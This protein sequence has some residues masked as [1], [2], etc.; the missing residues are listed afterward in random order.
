MLTPKHITTMK[1]SIKTLLFLVLVS[2]LACQKE[3]SVTP[4]PTPTPTPTKPD[5]TDQTQATNQSAVMASA[6]YD[7]VVT[8]DDAMDEN[9]DGVPNARI[10]ASCGAVKLDKANKSVSI[11]YGSG[12]ESR[13]GTQKKGKITVKYAGDPKVGAGQTWSVIFEGYSI[14][15][16]AISGAV[17]VSYIY[18][19]DLNGFQA[20][21]SG[22]NVSVSD[23]KKGLSLTELNLGI[24][25]SMGA[26]PKDI[27]DN[28]TKMTGTMKGKNSDN[29]DFTAEVA[30]ELLFKG[31]CTESKNYVPTSGLMKASV[32]GVSASADFSAGSGDCNRTVKITYPNGDTETKDL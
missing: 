24:V 22:T 9:L 31:V 15:N 13:T 12:C 26:K 1:T 19:K 23:G 29:K 3:E 17:S 21:V 27:A 14:E 30:Q 11:D 2:M 8:V 32:S 16:Y 18:K 5:Y 25:I 10:G 28:E 6:M 7:M 4:T 20:S